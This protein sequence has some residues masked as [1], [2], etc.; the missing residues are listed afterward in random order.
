MNRRQFLSS[1]L[2][3]LVATSMN[4]PP[5]AAHPHQL[6]PQPFAPAQKPA[7]ARHPACLGTH[8]VQEFLQVLADPRD[9][10]GIDERPPFAAANTVAAATKGAFV[11][12][13]LQV[14]H[15]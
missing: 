11:R 6:F 14:D 15:R 5:A 9:L 12:R 1:S 2:V 10:V 8:Q 7:P 13:G 4:A 3:P